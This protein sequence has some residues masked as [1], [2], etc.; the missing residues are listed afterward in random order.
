M[1][2]GKLGKEKRT[3]RRR[4]STAAQESL[5]FGDDGKG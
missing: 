3:T 5:L 1:R 2:G 4:Q